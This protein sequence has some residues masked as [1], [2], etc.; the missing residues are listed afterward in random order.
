MSHQTGIIANE[1]LRE[2]FASSKDGSVRVIKISIDK[3]EL[4]FAESA[5]PMD[6][7]IDDIL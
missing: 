2:A 6:N 5:S 3:E 1:E 4:V 7:W